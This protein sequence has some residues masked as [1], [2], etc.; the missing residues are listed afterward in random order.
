MALLCV[1]GSTA[2]GLLIKVYQLVE[3]NVVQPLAYLQLAFATGYGVL[4]FG[5][6][7]DIWTWVGMAILV[8]SGAWAARTSQ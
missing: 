2:H 5:E 3:A 7:P 4:L 1:L 8:L 6:K